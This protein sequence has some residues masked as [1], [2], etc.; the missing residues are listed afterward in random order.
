[1]ET[2]TLA[3]NEV[4]PAVI[5]TVTIPE[6]ARPFCDAW[7]NFLKEPLKTIE[8]NHDGNFINVFIYEHEKLF[9]FGYQLK[10]GKIIRQKKAAIFDRPLETI[11][12]ARRAAQDE[13][14]SFVSERKL[15]KV[16]IYFDKICYNQPELF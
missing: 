9:Y 3:E 7:G 15:K 1:M 16:F 10:L 12:T 6:A 4:S 2:E 11:D 8:E 13:L 14:K 5:E